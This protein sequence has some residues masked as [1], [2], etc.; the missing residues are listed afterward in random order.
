M[1]N[2]TTLIIKA[3]TSHLV[4]N[5]CY[6]FGHTKSDHALAIASAVR[7]V[8]ERTSYSD[9]LYHDVEHT[10]MVTLLGTDDP[11]RPRTRGTWSRAEDWL[12]MTVALLC[13]DVGYVRGACRGDTAT[14]AVVDLPGSRWPCRAAPPTPG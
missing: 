10:V 11:A 12:H 8:L 2:T 7:L 13:H 5:Y 14:E 4:D 3:I 1:H 6:I 9:A